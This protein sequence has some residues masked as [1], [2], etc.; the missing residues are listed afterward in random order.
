MTSGLAMHELASNEPVTSLVRSLAT[1]S[2]SSPAIRAETGFT[3]RNE[4]TSYP[5]FSA[6]TASEKPGYEAFAKLCQNMSG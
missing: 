1:Q 3:Y 6:L 4:T 2:F 5:G